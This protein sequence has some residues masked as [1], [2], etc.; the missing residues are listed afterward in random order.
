MPLRRNQIRDRR[1]PVVV[2]HCHCTDCQRLSGAGHT[3]GAVYPE[4]AVEISGETTEYRLKS[5]LQSVVTRTFCPSCGS[6]LFGRNTRMPGFITV[7]AGTLDDPDGVSP[8]VAFSPAVGDD[9]TSW[10]RPSHIRFTARLETR[11]REM[12]G[13]RP[14]VAVGL[15]AQPG[16]RQSGRRSAR[17]SLS[18]K[19]AYRPRVPGACYSRSHDRQAPVRGHPHSPL[20]P[21]RRLEGPRRFRWGTPLGQRILPL[22]TGHDCG[23]RRDGAAC[24]LI[25]PLMGRTQVREELTEYQPGEALAYALDGPAGPFAS[26]ASRWATRR[27]DDCST[28]VTVEGNFTPRNALARFIVWPLAKPMIRRLTGR[29]LAE[30]EAFLT[31]QE[32]SAATSASG[33]GGRPYATDVVRFTGRRQGHFQATRTRQAGGGE[34]PAPP[35][36]VPRRV[37]S[38]CADGRPR[39]CRPA[40]AAP[41]ESHPRGRNRIAT[42]AA[43]GSA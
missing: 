3:T 24:T 41:P 40:D 34:A 4:S 22:R 30:L 11:R 16:P 13:A 5:E 38:R 15:T 12:I 39:D 42:P 21:G 17:S 6:P 27:L 23:R 37:P 9:G 19:A 35:P 8:Q 43:Q 14:R 26:A 10:M 32:P 29:V 7:T 33:M 31:A 1:R 25:K 18:Q 20:T 36:W 28:L 2:A